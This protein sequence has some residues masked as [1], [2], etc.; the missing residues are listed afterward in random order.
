MYIHIYYFL[1]QPKLVS[2]LLEKK[3]KIKKRNES[4]VDKV[5]TN[6]PLAVIRFKYDA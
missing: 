5:G 1:D 2:L 6:D 4:F 3:K